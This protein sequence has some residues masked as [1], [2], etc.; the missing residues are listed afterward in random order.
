MHNVCSLDF[1]EQNTVF[2]DHNSAHATVMQWLMAM[3]LP[4]NPLR[5]PLE[6][7]GV[8]VM[9]T[10]PHTLLLVGHNSR[11]LS[12]W[13]DIPH[14]AHTHTITISS[15]MVLPSVEAFPTNITSSARARLSHSTTPA[16]LRGFIPASTCVVRAR[17]PAPRR[18]VWVRK[19][20]SS[21]GA[22]F[23]GREAVLDR[24]IMF[25]WTALVRANFLLV[26]DASSELS[27]AAHLPTQII[28]CFSPHRPDARPPLLLV[29]LRHF[30][31]R[32]PAYGGRLPVGA[33]QAIL[34]MRCVGRPSGKDVFEGKVDTVAKHVVVR[35]QRCPCQIL[36]ATQ[37]PSRRGWAMANFHTPRLE[38]LDVPDVLL[39]VPPPPALLRHFHRLAPPN[40]SRP[41]SRRRRCAIRVPDDYSL[42]RRQV[43]EDLAA[44][45]LAGAARYVD[46]SDLECWSSRPMP[47]RLGQ[48]SM[49]VRLIHTL[50]AL[51]WA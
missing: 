25:C 27:S 46:V 17:P 26:F 15:N 34:N 21:V 49:T 6:S 28:L 10:A 31:R 40:A 48:H 23:P 41:F 5:E 11:S 16:L 44:P 42:H 29:K 3:F 12:L 20:D 7:R 32:C 8:H 22:P 37:S 50:F 51:F 33:T 18:L 45:F 9:A 47:M 2:K 4:P 39:R 13:I 43:V 19:W 14:I 30:P 36:M 24:P 1:L 38:H 35:V